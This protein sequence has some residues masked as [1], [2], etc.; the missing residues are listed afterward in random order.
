MIC[1]VQSQELDTELAG[2]MCTVDEKFR[3]MSEK[4]EI[5][6]VVAGSLL[7]RHSAPEVDR[8]IQSIRYVGVREHVLLTMRK[9]E[10][11]PVVNVI[12]VARMSLRQSQSH[13]Q[14]MRRLK[15]ANN[16]HD[17]HNWTIRITRRICAQC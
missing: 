3:E 10:V 16:T 13:L 14:P 6:G 17:G 4:P 9:S 12:L 11:E 7:Q 5:V 1:D 2:L 15:W 8:W